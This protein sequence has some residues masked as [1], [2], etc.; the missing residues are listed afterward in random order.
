MNHLA[1][2]KSLKDVIAEY[3]EKKAAI[4][5]SLESFSKAGDALKLSVTIGGTWGNERI[6]TGSVSQYEAERSLLK[7]AWL[8]I[9]KGLN[10][11]QIASAKDRKRWEQGVENPAPFTMDNIRATL[12]DYILNPRDNILRGLAEAFCDLDPAFK[13]HDKI[14]IGVKGLPKRVILN[15]MGGYSYG[16]WGR[17]KLKD[18][19]NSLASYQGRPIPEHQDIEHLIKM[20]SLSGSGLTLKKYQNG[21][22][23]LYFSPEALRDINFALAEFYGDVLPDTTEEKP[24]QKSASTAVSKDL[25]YY[26]TPIAVVEDVLSRIHIEKGQKILEPSCGCG[27]FMDALR[28]AGASVYGIE[29]DAGRAAIAKAKGHIVLKAN[30]LETLP[31]GDFD[32]VVMNPPF[33]GKHYARHVKH[34]LE[35]LKPEGVLTAIL[36]I[37][38]RYDHGLLDG[39]WEDLPVGSFAE[40]GTNINTTI[41]TIRKEAA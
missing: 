15:G 39:R 6:E 38:A 5:E 29:Y 20:G 12:G 4:A 28:K 26:P 22:G 3:D 27:R 25:Q 41:L 19:M 1:L 36:P 30:F 34:A 16:S 21:N 37:T 32:R 2:Q 24:M 35:F 40:S 14:R 23:H 31:T 17:E 10:I 9:Y 18:I 7:S 33:Y 13:S 11:K 8:H